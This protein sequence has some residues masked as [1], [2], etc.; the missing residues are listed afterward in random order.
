MKLLV[1]LD[2]SELS[3]AA[4]EPAQR[5]AAATAGEVHL[6][7]VLDVS[8]V[9]EKTRGK[10]APNR[11]VTGDWSG[12]SLPG[13]GGGS[14]SRKRRESTMMLE[15]RGQAVARLEDAAGDAIRDIATTFSGDVTCKVVEGS[16]A[17][18]AITGYAGEIDA[19]FIVMATHS[20]KGLGRMLF[21]STTSD[22]VESGVAPVLV[23][24]PTVG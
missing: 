22:D 4:L 14:Q 18:A 6:L 9:H 20:R 1:C 15:D 24:H 8:D 16:N 11:R 7:R 2:G 13:A 10:M 23:V 3:L 21:G 19:D 5:M 12:G 17:A